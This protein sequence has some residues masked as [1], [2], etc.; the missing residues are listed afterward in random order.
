M[1]SKIFKLFH[2]VVGWIDDIN[3]RCYRPPHGFKF[4]RE[5]RGAKEYAAE[6]VDAWKKRIAQCPKT[7]DSPVAF[8]S[9]GRIFWP[10]I[11][12]M[13]NPIALKHE[14]SHVEDHKKLGAE[15]H[16]KMYNRCDKVFGYEDNPFEIKARRAE[17]G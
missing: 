12:A 6:N 8:A 11:E 10:S 2:K 5:D 13:N 7:K 14:L 16:N 1:V 9:D 3:E 4:V 15:T 17:R